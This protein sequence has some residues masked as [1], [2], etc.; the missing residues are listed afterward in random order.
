MPSPVGLMATPGDNPPSPISEQTTRSREPRRAALVI[1]FLH[2]T[3]AIRDHGSGSHNG[4]M[5]G[6]RSVQRAA[7]Q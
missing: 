3:L 1:V 5:D 7:H 2:S 4:G 6:V